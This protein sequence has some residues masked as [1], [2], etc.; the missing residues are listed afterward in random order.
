MNWYSIFYWISV[1]DGIKTITGTIA[2]ISLIFWIISVAC[3]FVASRYL[4]A[5][6]HSVPDEKQSIDHK[7][8]SIW[9]KTWRRVFTTLLVVSIISAL[10]NVAIPS[11]KDCLVIIAGGAVGNFITRDSS[12]KQ[13]PS[14]VMTLL[15]TKIQSEIGG[16]SLTGV[17]DTLESMT[18]EQLIEILRKKGGS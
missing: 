6:V 18:K 10:I 12:A 13:I 2:V 15:R 11:R 8:W 14:E 7:E 17:K 5:T 1:A 16:I 9:T 3:L 4:A